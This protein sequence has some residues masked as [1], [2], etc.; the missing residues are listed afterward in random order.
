[1]GLVFALVVGGGLALRGATFTTGMVHD[2]LAAQ[3]I[4]FPPR[5]APA[6]DPAK[7]PGLQRY[8]GQTVDDGPKAKAFAD[9]Y[10][11]TH[12][13]SVAEG[14]TYAEVSGAARVNPGDQK[15]AGQKQALFEG[16]ALRGMLLSAWGW[17][18]VGSITGL[19]AY[20][21]FAA[22]AMVLALLVLGS[23]RRSGGGRGRAPA[24]ASA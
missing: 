4:T 5:G 13:Q 6:L 9:Q 3:K 10:I 1:L 18:V 14:R 23:A 15:L 19:V 2:Q 21:A 20:G 8:A 11:A 17:S 7:F 22:A 16:E 24:E 12:L